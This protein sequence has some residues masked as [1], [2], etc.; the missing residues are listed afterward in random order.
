[1]NNK[2]LLLQEISNKWGWF[3]GIGILMIILGSI[4]LGATFAVTLTT[5]TFFGILI[6]IGGIGQLIDAFKHKGL[7]LA[8]KLLIA[9]LYVAVGYV[10]FANPL[11]ASSAL[12]LFIAWSLIVIGILRILIAISNYGMPGWLWVLIGGI[13]AVVL[14]VM[15]L[16]N[17]PV[18]GLWVIGM[19]VAIEL[20]L[21]GW[22]MVMTG[23]AAKK[24][25]DF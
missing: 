22:A 1:M 18:S 3:L 16:N 6:F 14:G 17:W 13:A 11:L 15:I 20:I 19:F 21:N 8:G 4:G 10:M 5:V 9:L 25:K 23:L 7:S 12:T 24:M 2:E